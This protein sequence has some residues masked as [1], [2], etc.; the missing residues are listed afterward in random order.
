[1]KIKFVNEVNHL[2]EGYELPRPLSYYITFAN[3]AFEAIDSNK[4]E[5]IQLLEDAYVDFCERISYELKEKK[6]F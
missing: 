3:Y 5:F 1:M 4:S 2:I 6:E